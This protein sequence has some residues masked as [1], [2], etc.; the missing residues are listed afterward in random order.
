MTGAALILM[1]SQLSQLFRVPLKSNDQ[2]L[3]G[4][5]AYRSYAPLHDLITFAPSH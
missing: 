2:T 1:A 4:L 3:P 5:I